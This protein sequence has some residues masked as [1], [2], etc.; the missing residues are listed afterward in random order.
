MKVP[1]HAVIFMISTIGTYR[2]SNDELFQ[3][4]KTHCLFDNN[5]KI[6]LML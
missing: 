5:G 1:Y 3:I 6:A 2:N 4:M